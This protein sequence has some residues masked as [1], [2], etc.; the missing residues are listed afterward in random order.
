MKNKFS[1][2]YD[3][4]SDRLFISCKKDSDIIK[5]SIRILNLILDFTTDNKIV[6]VELKKASEYLK[7][8]KINP[9]ILN[10][11]TNAEIVF[12]QCRDGFLISFLLQDKNKIE[13]IPYNIYSQ[14]PVLLN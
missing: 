8:L 10:N 3:D 14:K 4:F 2:M 12:K 5:G 7:L 1:F 13:K 11:L 9:K 6:N